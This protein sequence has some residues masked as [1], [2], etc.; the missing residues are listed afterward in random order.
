LLSNPYHRFC[1][2]FGER[3][4]LD[5][6]P[7]D[8]N[9]LAVCDHDIGKMKEEPVALRDYNKDFNP[10]DLYNPLT[11]NHDIPFTAPKAHYRTPSLV[12]TWPPRRIYTTTR[13]ASTM[14]TRQ[15]PAAWPHT[16]TG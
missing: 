11:G 3:L 13:S 6:E 15:S 2:P 7:N 14:V 12:S 9:L 4:A 16:R 5:P 10:I 8:W 1:V